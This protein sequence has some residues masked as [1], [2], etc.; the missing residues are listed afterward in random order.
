M[1]R[2]RVLFVAE[3]AP[4]WRSRPPLVVDCSVVAS[5]LFEE[6]DADQAGRAL[7]GHALH[8]PALLPFEFANVARN[9]TRAGAPAERVRAAIASY[10]EMLIDL[11][12]V[13]PDEL[14]AVALRHELTAYDAAYLV[15]AATLRAPLL[16]FD[17]RLADAAARELGTLD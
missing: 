16:T 6:S 13:P 12:P 9:K 3:P 8:A 14:L 10:T 15:L 7:S 11:H 4:V 2:S 5:W 1:P 17:R